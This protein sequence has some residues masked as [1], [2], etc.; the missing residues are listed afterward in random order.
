[1]LLIS[2]RTKRFIAHVNPIA[3]AP[4]FGTGRGILQVI[5]AVMLVHPAAFHKTGQEYIIII[6]AET[7]PAVF[8]PVEL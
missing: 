7:F 1:M 5:F 2:E 4:A 3:I 6:L 8:F